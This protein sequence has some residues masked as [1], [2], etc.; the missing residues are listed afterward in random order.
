MNQIQSGEIEVRTDDTYDEL[1]ELMD[2]S[3]FLDLLEMKSG[4]AKFDDY[5]V[6]INLV[7]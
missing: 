1:E 2:S 7:Q 5:Q 6:L 3:D 4:N